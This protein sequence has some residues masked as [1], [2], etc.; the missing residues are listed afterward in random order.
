MSRSESERACFGLRESDHKAAFEADAARY[1]AGFDLSPSERHAIATGDV[2][3]L[4]THG[5]IYGA[6]DALGRQFG[7]DNETYVG[8]LRQAAGRPVNPDQIA[9]LRKRAAARRNG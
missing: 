3:A 7:Y 2:G 5:L 9:L 4:L 8:R 6:L 1:L